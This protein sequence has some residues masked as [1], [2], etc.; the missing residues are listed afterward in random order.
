MAEHKQWLFWQDKPNPSPVF[1]Q[2]ERGGSFGAN[3]LI[4]RLKSSGSL[5]KMIGKNVMGFKAE[6]E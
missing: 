4:I 2:E 5:G 3:Y 1:S 6:I